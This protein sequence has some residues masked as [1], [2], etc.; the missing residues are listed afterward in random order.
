M[1]LD[2]N[3]V[4]LL[5]FTNNNL[6]KDECENIWEIYNPKL[7]FK[8]NE[9]YKFDGSSYKIKGYSYLYTK[10]IDTNKLFNNNF[11]IDFWFSLDKYIYDGGIISCAVKKYYGFSLI[12]HKELRTLEL[13]MNSNNGY[14]NFILNKKIELNT[15]YH[16]LLSKNN[17]VL[18]YFI[19]GELIHEF[20][21]IVFI[22]LGKSI[23][24]GNYH[25]INPNSDNFQGNIDEFRIRNIYVDNFK[26]PTSSYKI[27]NYSLYT[28][29]IENYNTNKY[30]IK[31]IIYKFNVYKYNTQYKISF[32]IIRKVKCNSKKI[33]NIVRNIKFNTKEI[34]N[35]TRNINNIKP[36]IN[37]NA[38][39]YGFVFDTNYLYT[40]KN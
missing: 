27:K 17:E 13:C 37:Y 19:N 20:K 23:I 11:T 40:I 5:H 7:S 33:F 21:N 29:I 3:I 31:N 4:S 24:L 34:F 10:D 36:E 38:T 30:I 1:I 14:I 9:Y 35:T 26:I 15:W 18:R 16:L 2:A 6:V 8:D 12:I 32:D 22:G 25:Y 39:T 28:E